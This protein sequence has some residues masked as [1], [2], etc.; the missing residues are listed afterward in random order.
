MPLRSVLFNTFCL[1]KKFLVFNL[2]GKNLKRKYRRSYFGFLWT[3]LAPTAMAVVYYFVFKMVLH[4]RI[5]HYVAFVLTG[6]LPWAFFAGSLSEGM[7]SIVGN[8]NLASKVPIPVQVFPFS[9]SVT[10]VINFG[11]SIPVLLAASFVS[12]V[13]LSDS[14]VL[15][16]LIFFFLFLTTYG[17]ALILS[18]VFVYLRDLRHILSILLQIWFYGTPVVY[19]ENMIPPQFH[20]VIYANPVGTVFVALHRVLAEGAWPDQTTLLCSGLWSL[21]LLALGTLALE[22]LGAEV[23]EV[24]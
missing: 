1:G 11:F 6:V 20:W 14:L 21:G 7:E 22:R 23:V 24:A 8:W 3:L 15:L 13:E 10:N 16:P 9:V 4:V 5:P 2:V 19:S 12:R 18:L 17:L